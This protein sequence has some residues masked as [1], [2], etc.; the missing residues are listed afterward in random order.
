[1]ILERL[2][3][4]HRFSADPDFK[5][6]K[7]LW[8]SVTFGCDTMLHPKK[9]N[10]ITP[11]M[12]ISWSFILLRECFDMLTSIGFG[13]FIRVFWSSRR[14]DRVYLGRFI[15]A[16][17]LTLFTMQDLRRLLNALYSFGPIGPSLITGFQVYLSKCWG[18]YVSP[19]CTICFSIVLFPYFSM[20]MLSLSIKVMAPKSTSFSPGFCVRRPRE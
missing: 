14:Y 11:V 5:S 1:M 4:Y 6:S 17:V 19:S 9:L 10:V 2:E 8:H 3:T 15:F 20:L 13:D 12:G 7:G 16:L 18:S